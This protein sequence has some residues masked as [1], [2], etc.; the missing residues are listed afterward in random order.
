MTEFPGK[1]L[2]LSNLLGDGD[3]SAGIPDCMQEILAPFYDAN[4]STDDCGEEQ[5]R[6]LRDAAERNDTDAIKHAAHSLKGVAATAGAERLSLA[7]EKW[8]EKEPD[9]EGI[10]ALFDLLAV[11]RAEFN[12]RSAIGGE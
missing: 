12:R 1:I 11:T 2:D 5:L 9:V 6:R 3:D 7:V 10:A 8:R 4:G